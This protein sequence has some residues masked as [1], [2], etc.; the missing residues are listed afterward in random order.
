MTKQAIIFPGQGAQHKGMGEA[1]F[2]AF[3][4]LVAVADRVLG[5]SIRQLCLQDADDL[6]GQTRYTQPALFVVNALAYRQHLASGAAP[7]DYLAGHSLGEYSALFAAGVFDF[8]TGLQLVA[9]RG[10]LMSQAVGGG[11]A[12]VLGLTEAQVQAVIGECAPLRLELANYN[13]PTQF[14]LAG[15]RQDVLQAQALFLQRGAS[16][17]RV[18][19]VSGAFHSSL[20][21]AARTEFEAYIRNF[22]LAPPRI[23]VI[24]NLQARPYPAERLAETLAAQ[25]NSPVRWA[26]SMRYLLGESVGQFIELGP[27]KVLT[28]LMDAIQREAATVPQTAA[29]QQAAPNGPSGRISAA[30]LGSPAFKADYRLDYAYVVG[31]M[32][33]GVA[34]KELVADVAKSGMLAFFGTGGL[35][36]QTIEEAVIHLQRE[37]AGRTFGV[38]L[39]CNAAEEAVVDIL[40]RHRVRCVEA[41]AFIQMTPALVKYRLLGLRRDAR[42]ETVSDH[43]VLAKLSRS[44][45]ATHFLSPAPEPLVRQLLAR[46]EISA[47]QAELAAHYPMADHI[48]AEADSAGHTDQAN[49]YA[50]LPSICRLRDRMVAEKGYSRTI[51]VGAAGGIGTP[52]AAAAAFILGADFILTGSINQCTLEAATSELVKDLL[53]QANVQDTDYAPAGDMFELGAKV[54]VLRR[55]VFFPARA[56]KLYA[57]YRHHESLDEIAPKTREQIEQGYFK[58]SFA[59]I[60]EQLK[61][62]YPAEEIRRAEENPKH[63]MALVFGWYFW[64]SSRFALQ[65][66]TERKVDFQIHCGPAM[67]A[68][69]QW[70]KGSELEPWRKRH[71][72]DIGR[73]IMAGA[74]EVLNQRYQAFI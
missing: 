74:A 11:M 31:G 17:Y 38:N 27:G 43:L 12:V 5:Y 70:V 26:D 20:M 36:P 9:K 39:L 10:E 65:G 34:S 60:Y 22:S 25:I 29:P 41:A 64:A 52:E 19:N 15:P 16:L 2:T 14:V 57:L 67:G 37:L 72:G 56:N 47:E 51:C 46:G 49:I 3:P 33:Q 53:Q 1:L 58:I 35:P 59:E 42:G 66:V 18:L 6:L 68:F 71:A 44:E 69:N 8:A 54:Q 55:G 45:V 63:K 28:R 73:R 50:L 62:V 21:D 4:D 48:C 32:Y 30:S 40:L 23:P 7:P 13:S 24:S 61:G